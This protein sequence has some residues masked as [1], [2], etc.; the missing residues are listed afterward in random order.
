MEGAHHIR[1]DYHKKEKHK[2]ELKYKILKKKK[3][4]VINITLEK[5]IKKYARKKKQKKSWDN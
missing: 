4:D 5:I 2:K 1:K 3:M